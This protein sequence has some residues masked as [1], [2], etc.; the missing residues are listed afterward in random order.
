M[1]VHALVIDTLDNVII[2]DDGVVY[3]LPA[4]AMH[5]PRILLQLG[6]ETFHLSGVIVIPGPWY[7][8][9]ARDLARGAGWRVPDYRSEDI[10]MVNNTDAVWTTYFRP[11][12]PTI[13]V[14][15]SAGV[16]PDRHRLFDPNEHPASIANRLG[17][18]HSAVGVPWRMTAGVTGCDLLRDLKSKSGA[19]R[20]QPRWQWDAVTDCPPGMGDLLWHREVTT[21]PDTGDDGCSDRWV[22]GFDLRGQYLAAAGVT[23]LP[24]GLPR[25][26]QLVPAFDPELAGWWQCRT[27]DLPDWATSG[28]V[29]PPIVDPAAFEGE[30]VWLSAATMAVLVDNA[31]ALDPFG[32]VGAEHNSRLMRP[33]SE[34]LRDARRTAS[35]TG[36]ERLTWA[37]KDTANETIGMFNKTGGRVWR[38]D[39][40]HL[41]IDT[42]RA[43][44]LRKVRS[45]WVRLGRWPVAIRTDC[46]WYR[47]TT[48]AEAFALAAGF[49]IG[50]DLGQWAHVTSIPADVFDSR[51]A[52]LGGYKAAE[53]RA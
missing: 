19:G 22:H 33:W 11:N 51:T 3:P 30:S 47:S 34:T 38:P 35:T 21:G 49:A 39:W 17:A 24:W 28:R 26:R 8:S 44:L 7:S 29:R 15:I 27:S 50:P 31:V 20:K 52:I 18:Y 36:D 12:T 41:V 45:A 37:V 46:V 43:N 6:A 9:R 10:P 5:D 32:F 1:P 16:N 13:H 23:R 40:R 53:V 48:N 2:R 42:A 4:G 14:C 25:R